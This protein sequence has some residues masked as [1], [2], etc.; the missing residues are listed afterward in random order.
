MKTAL[1]IV[2][3][4]NDFLPGG[5]L[6]VPDGDKI[7]PA[8]HNLINKAE[9]VVFTQD[10]HPKSHCSFKKYGGI[11]PK[12]CIT[13]TKGWEL[14]KSFD[15]YLKE[16]PNMIII[17]KGTDPYSDSYS[18]FMDENK[19]KTGLTHFLKQEKIDSLI[20][21]GLATEYCVKFTVLD[22]LENGFKVTVVQ[23]GIKGINK[24]DEEEALAFMVKKG[25]LLIHSKFIN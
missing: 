22:A 5:A 19:M 21:C 13:K 1:L 10:S 4:Q 11:W 14:H 16:I 8:I 17:R 3:V 12:H 25:V 6:P 23:D 24:R 2:D 9:Y 15:S 7:L 20:I 18:A